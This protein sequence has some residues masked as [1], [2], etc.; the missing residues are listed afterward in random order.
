MSAVALAKN[1]YWVGAVDWQIRDFHG[2]STYK[3]TTYNNYL[4]MDDKVTLID[5][6]KAPFIGETLHNISQ[7]IDPEKVD[8]LVVNHVEPDH[9]G[10][11]PGLVKKLKPEKVFAP[12]RGVIALK[13]HYP[14]AEDWPLVQVKDGETI[15]IGQ[16]SLTFIETRMIHWP[17]SM[18]SYCP[19]EEIL[20]SSDGF[21][22]HWATSQ[23][24]NDEVDGHEL[25]SHAAKYYSNILLLYS[26]LIQKLLAKVKDAGIGIKIIAPD[27][28]LIWRDNPGQ[29]IEAF[30][31]WSRQEAKAKAVV[32]YDTMW[33]STEQMA[34]AAVE[35]LTDAGIEV[36]LTDLKIDHRSDIVTEILDA[37]GVLVAS[38]TLNNGMLPTMA[39]F[40][41]YLRGLKPTGKVGAAIGSYGWSGEAVK[42]MNGL[43]EGMKVELIDE[44]IRCQYVPTE[45]TL[46]AC[47]ELGLKMAQAIKD[48]L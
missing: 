24:F 25:M 47:K 3:G 31:R 28:G 13:A 48:K 15:S 5:G 4:M 21:G 32:V 20:F 22:Q 45:E 14:E 18:F 44:G 19:E 16:R 23:R 35:G 7:V 33:H 39:D 8:Y 29:I 46:V 42:M 41:H 12:E 38:P 9:S 1:I 27:H 26:P 10:S 2:Y 6:V 36:K 17:D 37:K 43:L 11:L 40:L 30:D 34:L